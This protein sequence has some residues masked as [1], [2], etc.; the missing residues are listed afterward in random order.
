MQYFTCR[1]CGGLWRQQ[2]AV[3]ADRLVSKLDMLI[4]ADPPCPHPWWD[5]SGMP[6]EGISEAEAKAMLAPQRGVP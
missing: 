6:F 5:E 4:A 2:L 1:H 3:E